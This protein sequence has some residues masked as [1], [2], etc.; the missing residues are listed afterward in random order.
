MGGTKS[1][2]EG[3]PEWLTRV[4]DQDVQDISIINQGGDV[5]VL[6]VDRV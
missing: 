4:T 2:K 3:R 5:G 6:Y 1:G